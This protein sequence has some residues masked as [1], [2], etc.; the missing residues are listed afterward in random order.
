MADRP[1]GPASSTQLARRC[2]ARRTWLFVPRAR[3]FFRRMR[4]DDGTWLGHV[5]EHVAI[6]L[7]NI[8]GE[9]VTFGK[10]RSADPPASIRW[11]TN[12]RSATKASPPASSACGCCARCCPRP[13]APAGS[14]P[15]AGVGRRRAMSSSASRSAA[16]WGPRPPRWCARPNARHSLAAAQRPVA[17]A[18]RPRQVP[19]AHPGHGH[20]PHAAYRGR[21]GQRQGRDQQD[22]R[23]AGV[24]GAEAGA[25]AERGG[26]ARGARIGF[27]GGDETLQRQSRPRHLD[28]AHDR[29]GSA[30]GFAVAREHSRS[31]I[32]ETFLEGRRSS[33]AGGQRRTGRRHATHARPRGRRRQHTIA[34]LIEIVNQDPRRGVGHEKVL[35]RL[36]LDAQA[37]MMLERVGC[38]P[39]RCRRRTRSS[40]CDPPRICPPAARPPTSPTSS[41]P[42]IARWRS[43]P[44]APSA[45]TWAAWISLQGHHRE[46]PHHRRRHLRGERRAGLSACTWRRAK[47][48]RAM[49]PAR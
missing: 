28:P 43:A 45:W 10:T 41:I 46:L 27:P 12:T 25:G 33:P 6:E 14:V 8:A 42:T 24:A 34:Q 40:I 26:G 37:Q 21:A 5:L 36:E 23:H 15:E 35:T 29:R 18:T 1:L 11:S 39:T 20:Q 4:E 19:A 44:C 16:R 49:S 48:R 38:T 9:E 3:R 47:A 7:Q 13:S 17:G 32:V 31:V 2:P 30:P 22:P